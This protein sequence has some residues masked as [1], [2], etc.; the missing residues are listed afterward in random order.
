MATIEVIK[1]ILKL[2]ISIIIGL[3]L[4]NLRLGEVKS[5]A[6]GRYGEYR[7]K[8]KDRRDTDIDKKMAYEDMEATLTSRGIKYRMG[9]SFSPFDYTMFRI[10]CAVGGGVFF[11]I[12]HPL[13]FVP[14]LFVG[15]WAT[16]WYFKHKDDYD[17][18]EM[19]ADIS[20]LFGIVSLQLRN[21]VFVKDVIYECFLCVEHPRL[22]KALL[23]LSLEIGQFSDIKTAADNFRRKFN[24]EYLDMFSKTLEQ[25]QDSGSAVNL[26]EDLEGQIR[27]INEANAIRA[28]KHVDD[29]ASVFMILIFLSAMLF[30]AYVLLTMLGSAEFL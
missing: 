24:N 10:L 18:G 29:V 3:V 16:G 11:T 30:V 23:E 9:D 5:K 7:R 6:K 22:K 1:L 27:S 21:N 8:D 28:E 19:M 4:A 25:L 26:F 15:Y 13:A 20:Q 2:V 14:G 12:F 17:N